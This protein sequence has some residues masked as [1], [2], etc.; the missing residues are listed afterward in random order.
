MKNCYVVQHSDQMHCHKCKLTWDMNDQYPPECEGNNVKVGDS[1][2]W[3]G[4]KV[5]SCKDDDKFSIGNNYRVCMIHESNGDV[6]IE[7]PD[8]RYNHI[9]IRA[10]ITEYEN[11]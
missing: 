9:I 8:Y 5:G 4:R 10:G 1:V 2:K 6:E 11:N 7:L 3:L